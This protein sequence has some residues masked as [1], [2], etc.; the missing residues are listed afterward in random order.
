VRLWRRRG[1]LYRGRPLRDWILTV[2][3]DGA[4]AITAPWI[5]PEPCVSCG[6]LTVMRW[7]EYFTPKLWPVHAE[8]LGAKRRELLAEAAAT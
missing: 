3:C 5:K 2:D 6:R 4:C 8:C 7:H 1:P